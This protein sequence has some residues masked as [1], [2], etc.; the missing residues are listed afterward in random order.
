MRVRVLTLFVKKT[1]KTKKNNKGRYNI[2]S[3]GRI[4][5]HYPYICLYHT[6][7][8]RLPQYLPYGWRCPTSALRRHLSPAHITPSLRRPRHQLKLPALFMP[9]RIRQRPTCRLARVCNGPELIEPKVAPRSAL[10]LHKPLY[11]VGSRSH[12]QHLEHA[13]AAST[14][15]LL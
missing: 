13:G 12:G 2:N 15:C 4:E 1:K 10:D 5:Q 3:S 11:L 8:I 7:P 14:C 9:S 6:P